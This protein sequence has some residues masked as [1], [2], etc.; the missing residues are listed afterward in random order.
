MLGG[1]DRRRLPQSRRA[2]PPD[3][4]QSRAARPYVGLTAEPAEPPEGT[5]VTVTT[6]LGEAPP[7]LAERMRQGQRAQIYHRALM[8]G[9][10]AG[11]WGRRPRPRAYPGAAQWPA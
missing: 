2:G 7:V 1:A 3:R 8:A 5:V 6:S 11:R 9:G 10:D 4:G